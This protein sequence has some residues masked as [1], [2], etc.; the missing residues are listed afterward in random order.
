MTEWTKKQDPMMCC[1]ET[2]LSF[3]GTHRLRVKGWKKLFQ[4]NGNHKKAGQLNLNQTKQTKLTNGQK[5][6]RR[7]LC[8]DKGVNH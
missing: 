6:Q 1:Q 7:S 8:N 2:H 5:R 3:K 4:A